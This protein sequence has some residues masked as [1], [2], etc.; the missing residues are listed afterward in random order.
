MT[1]PTDLVRLSTNPF[2]PENM[3]TKNLMDQA[4]KNDRD[5]NKR[6][7]ERASNDDSDD[8]N[9][10]SN[11]QTSSTIENY[12]FSE[13]FKKNQVKK[14]FERVPLLSKHIKTESSIKNSSSL[15]NI[16]FC[17]CIQ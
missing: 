4:L 8:E 14:T 10:T 13:K 9:P 3:I 7:L 5:R 2:S 15:R 12:V 16:F 17:C 11:S 6:L 1:W